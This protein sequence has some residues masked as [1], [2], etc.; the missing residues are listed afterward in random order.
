VEGDRK[1]EDYKV[2][3]KVVLKGNFFDIE[4]NAALAKR[5]EF[6]LSSTITD[7]V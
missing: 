5:G 1:R 6:T 2:D 3:I 7:P 4:V